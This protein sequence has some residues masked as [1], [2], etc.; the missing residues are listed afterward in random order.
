VLSVDVQAPPSSA[1]PITVDPAFQD[2][3][4][5]EYGDGEWFYADARRRGGSP[6]VRPGLISLAGWGVG[7][8]GLH[9]RRFAQAR[10]S[11]RKAAQSPAPPGHARSKCAQYRGEHFQLLGS[12]NPQGWSGPKRW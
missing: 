8:C 7:L 10:L 9:R 1:F 5:F 2:P 11:L 12:A 4:Y 3:F 6:N